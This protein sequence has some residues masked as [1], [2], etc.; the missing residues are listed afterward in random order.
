MTSTPEARLML[1]HSVTQLFESLSP[2][3]AA[4]VAVEWRDLGIDVAAL[5]PSYP[6]EQWR[7]AV[8]CAAAHLDG[9]PAARLREL[10]RGLFVRF[11]QSFL[12]KAAGPL[13]RLIGTRRSLLSSSSTFGSGNNYLT[14]E[15]ELDEPTHVRLRANEVMPLAELL[16]GS[17]EGLVTYTGG[18]QAEVGVTL[19]SA[20]T[21]YDI[22]WR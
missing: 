14:T 17:I 1:A 15:V 16:A 5:L 4:L 21:L 12:G 13:G 22:R 11:T 9:D 2:E 18:K 6:I 20:H 3:V 7:E 19:E 8:V 10:G